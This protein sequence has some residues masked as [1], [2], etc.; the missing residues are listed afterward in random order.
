[1]RIDAGDA[2]SPVDANEA[3][4]QKF[5]QGGDAER[6]LCSPKG[7]NCAMA[8]TTEAMIHGLLA[9]HPNLDAGDI[10]AHVS[11]IRVQLTGHVRT[12]RERDEAEAVVHQIRGVE[13][14]DNDLI[15]TGEPI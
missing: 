8:V 3:R 6:S 14:I 10:K 11:G 2:N 1:M 15:V 7:R 12:Q 13:E 5:W 4:E 9:E